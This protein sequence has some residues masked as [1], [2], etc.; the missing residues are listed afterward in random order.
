MT[1]LSSAYKRFHSEIATTALELQ[2][3]REHKFVENVGE[4]LVEAGELDD[5][6]RSSYKGYGMKVDGYCFD[7][8]FSNLNLIVAHWRDEPDFVNSKV[9]NT[10]VDVVFKRCVKFYQ[11][12][13]AGLHNRIEI[14]NEAHDLARLIKE[15]KKDIL[16]VRVIMVTDGL[17]EKRAA[18]IEVVDDIEFT[19]VIWDI[20]RILQFIEKGEKESVIVDFLESDGKP[21]PCIS[22]G[23]DGGI[24]ETFLAFIPAPILAEIYSRWGTKMLDMNVRV[25]LSARQGKWESTPF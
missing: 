3:L 10:E 25:F 9:T 13:K 19:F 20:E 15:M 12:S 22:Q 1:D 17:T 2:L 23:N 5:F 6:V 16:G 24:Y 8:E 14:A 7:E 21:I 11:R 4:I 18:S